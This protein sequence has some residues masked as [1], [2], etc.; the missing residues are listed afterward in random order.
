M[1]GINQDNKSINCG[2][3]QS[4]YTLE[5]PILQKLAGLIKN[6]RNQ[7]LDC[8]VVILDF[9][10]TGFS[11]EQDEIIEVAA[12]KIQPSQDAKIIDEFESLVRPGTS[13]P[14]NIV[15]IT[16]ITDEMVVEAPQ[17]SEVM[18]RLEKF[19]EGCAVVA[20]FADFDRKFFVANAV[21]KKLVQG[22]TFVDLFAM[23]VL[24]MPEIPRHRLAS[25]AEALNIQAEGAH[26]AMADVRVTAQVYTK[27]IARAKARGVDSF[28]ELELCMQSLLEP[29]R[30]MQCVA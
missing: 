20:H 23:A 12:V 5:I 13:I 17:I 21:D 15:E 19:C 25:V 8:D 27:L 3:M 18:P 4:I 24:L 16:G 7:S 11:A 28:S 6:N 30:S 14:K 9:E 2:N 26:R 22:L 10:T 1:C 29:I